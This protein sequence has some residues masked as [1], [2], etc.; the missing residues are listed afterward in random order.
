MLKAGN[1]RWSS[2]SCTARRSGSFQ[3]C[4]VKHAGLAARGRSGVLLH[5]S[6]VVSNRAPDRDAELNELTMRLKD[7]LAAEEHDL[8]RQVELLHNSGQFPNLR[9][10]I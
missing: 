10:C 4:R 5:S 3:G 1:G 6:N 9:L 8:S 2:P 7:N